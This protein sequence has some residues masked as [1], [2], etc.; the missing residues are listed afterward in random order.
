MGAGFA[1][2]AA[3]AVTVGVGAAAGV[4]VT[5]PVA[6]TATCAWKG[7]PSGN[8][9]KLVSVPAP[10]CGSGVAPDGSAAVGVEPGAAAAAP[11]G[12]LCSDFSRPGP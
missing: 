9:E 6:E 8:R 7:S 5:A 4:D 1:F 11:A 2:G 3:L 10:A 12:D